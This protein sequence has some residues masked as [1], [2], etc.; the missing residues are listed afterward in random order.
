MLFATRLLTKLE[1]EKLIK[2]KV[3]TFLF[4]EID[5]PIERET[6]VSSFNCTTQRVPST[7]YSWEQNDKLLQSFKEKFP[8]FFQWRQYD[9]ILA[10]QKAMYWANFRTGY[11]H[12]TKQQFYDKEEVLYIEPLH[13][14]NRLKVFVKYI[15]QVC[16][17]GE[18]QSSNPNKGK[19]IGC[20]GIF[21]KHAFQLTLY[22]HIVEKVKD[23]KRFVMY[24]LDASIKERLMSMGVEESNCVLLSGG[25]K[26][27]QLPII[28]LFALKDK[29]WYVLNQIIIHWREV[30]KWVSI[31]EQIAETGIK[32]F[33]MNEGEN[34]IMGA[35]LGEVMSKHGV[36]SF[37]TMN[38]T[39]SGE[40]QD[41][42]IN[43]DKWFVWDEKMKRLLVERNKLPANKLIVS[44]H[45]MEDTV[46]THSYQDSLGL[47]KEYLK[48]KK[49]ISVFSVRGKR[50]EKIDTFRMLYEVAKQDPAI[51]LL[52]RP[53]PSEISDDSFLPPKHLEN[54]KWV[55]YNQENSK[56]T[57]YDQLSISDVSICFGS[58]VALESKW[59]GVPC[60]TVEKRDESLIYAVDGEEIVHLKDTN[61]LEDTITK[62]LN[63]KLQ[64]RPHHIASVAK[65]I[66][67]WVSEGI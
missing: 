59:F 37:N 51:F 41:A 40:V 28:S 64:D 13:P 19:F 34:G 53:H 25:S 65:T 62:I 49:V 57:L 48:D 45:L 50:E 21:I 4:N 38:G 43:F 36:T 9:L 30:Q 61:Y 66:V 56:A 24:A 27:S 42:H 6:S 47:D 54:V 18:K 22:Q 10:F 33:L 26:I 5:F 17:K 32:T 1:Y 63:V 31:A 39:K 29:D 46:A 11:L 67:E 44:G 2:R 7:W 12:Y 60:I 23:D 35:V 52:V 15:K 3:T 58:T 20:H 8:Q 14:Y 55:S 16:A